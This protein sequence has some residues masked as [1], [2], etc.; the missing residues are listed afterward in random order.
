MGDTPAEIVRAVYDTWNGGDWGLERFHPDV[1]FQ[2][3]GGGSLDQLAP[4]RGHDSLLDYFRRFWS[5]WREGAQWVDE[6]RGL[7]AGMV[8]ASGRLKV[9]GRSS[10]IRTEIPFT[11]LWTVRNGLVVRLL[12]GEDPDDVLGNAE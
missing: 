1:E 9:V 5:A 11:H 8:L 7:E 3:I 12:A 4:T 10:G 2:V 6:V